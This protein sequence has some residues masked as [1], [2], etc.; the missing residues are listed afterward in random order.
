MPIVR[1]L[2]E[3]RVHTRNRMALED[4]HA[5]AMRRGTRIALVR[6]CTRVHVCAGHVRVQHRM[7]RP[8]RLQP[9]NLMEV[10]EADFGITP[11][12]PFIMDSNQRGQV[13]RH[14]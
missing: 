8:V 13:Y 4:A 11:A 12:V 5:L 1:T 7:R 9:V 10:G 2:R 6:D 14:D 3:H